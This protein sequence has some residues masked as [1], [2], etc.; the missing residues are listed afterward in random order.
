MIS[1]FDR[2]KS[3]KAIRKW[4]SNQ[5]FQPKA[6]KIEEM[7]RHAFS[8]FLYQ[9]CVQVLSKKKNILFCVPFH[10]FA[11]ILNMF[12]FKLVLYQV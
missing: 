9:H 2:I 3:N 1:A 7:C 4:I 6:A 10:C 12:L 8:D 11:M 5:N